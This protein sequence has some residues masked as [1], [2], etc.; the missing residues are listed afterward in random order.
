MQKL[1]GQKVTVRLDPG[2][3]SEPERDGTQ[4]NA[5]PVPE[6]VRALCCCSS[7]CDVSEARMDYSLQGTKCGQRVRLRQCTRQ[8][9]WVQLMSRVAW[10]RDRSGREEDDWIRCC[11]SRS[12]SRIQSVPWVVRHGFLVGEFGTAPSL[13]PLRHC[14]PSKEGHTEEKWPRWVSRS[15]GKDQASRNRSSDAA[16][17]LEDGSAKRRG[18]TNTSSQTQ[19]EC[20]L[21]DP[22]NVDLYCIVGARRRTTHWLVLREKRCQRQRCVKQP[23]SPHRYITR[24]MV[25]KHGPYLVCRSCHV[26]LGGHSNVCRS[27]FELSW[28]D[29][30][31]IEATAEAEKECEASQVEP[32]DD[33]ESVA[34]PTSEWDIGKFE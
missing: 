34:N 3:P 30:G 27:R 29:V 12:T 31:S 16:G 33:G 1:M 10:W 18:R 22:H 4:R 32:T 15:S 13:T 6:L 19:T 14:P 28:P 23:R 21:P 25:Q 7:G 24:A 2:N 8:K 11:R 17:V 9:T 26:L 20:T 5:S